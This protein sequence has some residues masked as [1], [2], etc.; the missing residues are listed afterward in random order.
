M[1]APGVVAQRAAAR[2][3]QPVEAAQAPGERTMA[4]SRAAEG[5]S[6]AAPQALVTVSCYRKHQPEQCASFGKVAGDFE[7]GIVHTNEITGLP[8]TAEKAIVAV[9]DAAGKLP[10]ID[11][12]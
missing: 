10:A 4:G 3:A 6:R 8:V 1:V 2:V 7:I 12:L 11:R 5:A 9:R